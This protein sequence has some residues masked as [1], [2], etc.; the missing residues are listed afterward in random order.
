MSLDASLSSDASADVI[1]TGVEYWLV[2]SA[3]SAEEEGV[4]RVLIGVGVLIGS[5][6]DRSCDLFCDL[7][8]AR[9]G[10]VAEFPSLRPWGD[11]VGGFADGGIGSESEGFGECARLGRGDSLLT[12]DFIET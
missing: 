12:F 2:A 1:N 8:A 11:L 5:I 6:P 7:R 3:L 10:I 4:R 9:V